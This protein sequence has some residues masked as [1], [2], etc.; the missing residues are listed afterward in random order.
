MTL[1]FLGATIN[2]I[3]HH[4]VHLQIE[5]STEQVGMDPAELHQQCL[6]LKK[7]LDKC[8]I[9]A[10]AVECKLEAEIKENNQLQTQVRQYNKESTPKVLLQELGSRGCYRR[11]SSCT[12]FGPL[13]V[14]R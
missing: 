6:R 1:N 2:D 13:H 7:E 14:M 11:Q 9:L 4:I 5:N 3:A 12:Q 8:C 10:K